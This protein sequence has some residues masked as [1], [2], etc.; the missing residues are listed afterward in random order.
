MAE[1]KALLY[2]LLLV[3][4]LLLHMPSTVP[5][6]NKALL[7]PESCSSTILQAT[8]KI[9]CHCPG[10]NWAGSPCSWDGYRGT[11]NFP[12]CLDVIPTN[13]DKATRS[14]VIKHL[15]SPTIQEWAFPNS[16][17]VCYLHI[18][19]SNVS[20]VQPGA[21]RGLPLV[22]TLSL[23]D[24]HI[25]S[26]EADTFLGLETMVILNLDRNAISIIS[27]HA[28]RG[29]PHLA[30]LQLAMNRLLSVPVDALLPPTALEVVKLQANHIATINS[31]VLRLLPT[32]IS[33]LMIVSNKLRCDGNLTWFICNLPDLEQISAPDILRC[34][35]PA[36]LRGTFLTTMRKDVCRAVMER[37][38]EGN[39]SNSTG[40]HTFNVSLYDKTI[41]TEMMY[42]YN[43]PGFEYTAGINTATLLKSPILIKD[44]DSHHINTIIMISAAVAPLL[45]VSV[46]VGVIYLFSRCCSTGLARRNAPAETNRSDKIEP[47]AVVYSNSAGLQASDRDSSPRRRPTPARDKTMAENDNIEPYTVSYVDVSGKG[48]NGKLAAYATTSFAHIT[49]KDND[50][51]QPYAP[52]AV[53]QDEDPGPQLQPYAVTQ[54]EDAGP[55]LQPYAVT[56]DED[57]GP[58]LQ[59]Y[60][61]TQDEDA[62]P[63]LQ[64]YAVTHDEDAGPQLQPYAVTQDE[65]PGPQL[66]PYAVTQDE[67]AGP[68]LQ[69]YAV[70]HDED[71]G[72]QLQPYAVT[73]DEDPGPQLQP[74]AVTHDEDAGPQL[75]PYSMTHENQGP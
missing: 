20:M 31:Q 39:T 4:S 72:P 36:E 67:D 9:I 8:G 21:F 63:Q 43:V 73:Q 33:R 10:R 69:P 14:I 74:Y 41:P 55:Q 54:D 37:S 6:V 38:H 5:S 1:K 70:T 13:F 48:K 51:I 19:N 71:A 52:Y 15:R 42:T 62:G 35:S 25:S 45:L 12:V 57:A 47:Y 2:L 23:A 32:Q 53:T 16:P 44:E 3:S 65:D 56:Q 50:D 22:N 58:Q 40:P 26:L 17:Q 46:F 29:L 75:Q 59:P 60:A 28:F 49:A 11:R 30:R 61:V 64:P 18:H 24:N 7:C 34:A 27:Q 66:Q 68:Q